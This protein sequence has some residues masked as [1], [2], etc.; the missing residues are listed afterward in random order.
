M[1]VVSGKNSFG[2]IG[3]VWVLATTLLAGCGRGEEEAPPR[4]APEGKDA[5]ASPPA[6]A[7]GRKLNIY[8]WSDYIA[9]DTIP[10]FESRTGIKVTYDVFDSNEVLEGKLLA[11][12]TGY[13]LVVPT[14]NFLAR[15]I[16]A[17]VFQ[18]L[19][20][21]KIPNLANLDPLLMQR[22]ADGDPGNQYAVPYLWGTTGIGYNVAKVKEILGDGAPVDSWDLVLKEENLAKL[23]KCGVAFLDAP[24]ELYPT[25]L[26]Y[27][28]KDPN[29]TNP[30]DY[31]GEA[32]ELLKKL[33]PHVTYFHSSKYIDDLAAGE[34][35]VVIGWS[36]DVFQAAD[37]ASEAGA[38]VEVAYSIPKEGALLWFDMLAI[39][40]DAANVDE[41][42]AFI[43]HVLDP[44]VMAGITNFVWYPNAVP[45]STQYVEEEI[46][47]DESVYPPEATMA[48]LFLAKVLPADVDRVMN[49]AWTEVKT[50]Q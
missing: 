11:G 35:C 21:D 22:V 25:V 31:Q 49:R 4:P 37:A 26:N 3:L 17:G 38:G 28:G 24:S 27:I 34:I 50:G 13:D 16:V 15:Q 6:P 43:N 14:I 40:A 42:H 8:N 18:P 2:F 44:Q 23:N 47:T 29:S 39:P 32:L 36:G 1:S 20:K 48:K 5:A 30:E 12:K 45:A 33:A 7:A 10:S 9:E 19:Q 41:A 46:R